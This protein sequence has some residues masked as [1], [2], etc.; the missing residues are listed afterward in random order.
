MLYMS[1]ILWSQLFQDHFFGEKEEARPFRK[2]R[3]RS[4][5]AQLFL[6]SKEAIPTHIRNCIGKKLGSHPN[7]FSNGLIEANFYRMVLKKECHK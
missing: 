2:K 4:S 6:L 3:S 7:A 1:Q 5:S